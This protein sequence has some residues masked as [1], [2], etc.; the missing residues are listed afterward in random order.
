MRYSPSPLFKGLGK[1]T[2]ENSIA[3]GENPA[4]PEEEA[5]MPVTHSG[6]LM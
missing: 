5:D 4:F 6:R 1:T 2:K 3:V